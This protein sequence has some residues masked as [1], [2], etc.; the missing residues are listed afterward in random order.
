MNRTTLVAVIAFA[1]LLVAVLALRY[2]PSDDEQ[3]SFTI[4]GWPMEQAPFDR[5]TIHRGGETIVLE[6]PGEEGWLITEPSHAVAD[7]AAVEAIFAGLT[8]PLTSSLSKELAPA[9]LPAF[10]LDKQRRIGLEL[11]AKGEVLLDVVV[12]GLEQDDGSPADTGTW[13]MKPGEETRAYRM[14]GVDLR[15]PVDKGRAALRSVKLFAHKVEDIT[16]LTVENSADGL[17]PV[18]VLERSEGESGWRFVKPK[19]YRPGAI[20]RYLED[21]LS[22][23]ALA[24]LP[25]DHEEGNQELSDAPLRVTMQ[26]AEGEVTVEVGPPGVRYGFL[27]VKGSDEIVRVSSGGAALFHK[28]FIDLRDKKLF[29]TPSDDVTSIELTNASGKLHAEKRGEDWKLI[30][31]RDVPLDGQ[32]FSAWRKRLVEMKA[33]NFVERQLPASETGLGSPAR[34]LVVKTKD[35]VHTLIVGA[36]KDG[37]TYATLVGDGELFMLSGGSLSHL[38]KTVDDLRRK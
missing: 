34:K 15:S 11:R 3:A 23:K 12:G 36:E 1:V 32:S 31:P 29:S 24:F 7:D 19:G 10:R 14:P 35:K 21:M 8:K 4:A 5:I 2:R 18:L 33:E 26:H 13:V 17:N 38:D 16:G 30:E 6:K 20:D 25:V 37:K 22:A 27:R 9:D 28:S